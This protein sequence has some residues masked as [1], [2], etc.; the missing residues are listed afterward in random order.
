MERHRRGKG[1]KAGGLIHPWERGRGVF[2]NA[3]PYDPRAHKVE[4]AVVRSRVI[5]I[6]LCRLSPSAPS[7]G[8]RP[9]AGAIPTRNVGVADMSCAI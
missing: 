1:R 6:S 4:A 5:S 9:L 7:H 2:R 8:W 3:K